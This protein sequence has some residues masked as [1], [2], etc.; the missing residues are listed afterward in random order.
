MQ[1]ESLQSENAELRRRLSDA[2]SGGCGPR[3][4]H[5]GHLDESYATT[6]PMHH[7]EAQRVS[8]RSVCA[9]PLALPANE[10]SLVSLS[11]TA[12]DLSALDLP[13]LSAFASSEVH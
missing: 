9:A 1:V 10:R 11:E 6:A 8:T 5:A 7:V 12:D 2:T 4:L 13:P 3:L